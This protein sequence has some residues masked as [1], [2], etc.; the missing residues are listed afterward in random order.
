MLVHIVSSP[1]TS[2]ADQLAA[3]KTSL[4]STVTRVRLK[5]GTIFEE[6]RAKDGHFQTSFAGKEAIPTF[7]SDMAQGI[8]RLTPRRFVKTEWVALTLDNLAAVA[9]VVDAPTTSS[10]TSTTSTT[11]AT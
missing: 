6:T 2:L 10:T 11:T 9:V 5:D 3:R 1:M 7:L 4:S 8:S